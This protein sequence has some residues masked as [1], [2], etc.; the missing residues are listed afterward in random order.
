MMNY[1][2]EMFFGEK[3]AG[4]FLSQHPFAKSRNEKSRNG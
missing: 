1:F 3:K 4:W 2:S